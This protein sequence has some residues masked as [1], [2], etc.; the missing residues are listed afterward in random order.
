MPVEPLRGALRD[1]WR[2]LGKELSA[3]GVVGATC[4][5]LDLALFQLLYVHVGA[6]A[7]TSKLVATLITM[8]L[9]FAGHRLW[10]F[11]HRARTG[12]TRESLRFAVVNGVTLGLGLGIVAFVRYPLG[13]DD[14]AVLQVAN[15]TAIAL[16]TVVRYLSYRHW[17]FPALPGPA[18]AADGRTV[19]A[20]AG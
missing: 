16:G 13:Q 19:S 18:T 5:V 15:V 3:F 8:A 2:V 14:A 1:R 10:S 12:L 11:S 6:G 4:F 20:H 17:V 7:V 9:A